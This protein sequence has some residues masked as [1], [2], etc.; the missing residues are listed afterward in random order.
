[1]PDCIHC[2][3]PATVIVTMEQGCFVF[4]DTPVQALCEQ[5][6]GRM[7][8]LGAVLDVKEVRND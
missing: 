3:R 4:R 5:H 2:G 7:S 6:F 1:M 8:P